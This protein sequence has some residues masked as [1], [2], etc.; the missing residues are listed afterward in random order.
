MG[1]SASVTYNQVRNTVQK[2][3]NTSYFTHIYSADITWT[4]P[5][6]F[7]LATDVDY[8]FNTGLASGFNQNFAI[9][10][11]SIA[12]EVFKTKRGEIRA[13]VF[14]LLNQNT[15]VYRTVNDNYVQDVQNLTLKRYFLLTFSYK[16]NRMGGRS[17]PPMIQRATRGMRIN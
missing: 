12:K 14:D 8:T 13:S 6:N 10:N 5:K 16:I 15:S 17:L 7:I 2:A 9:W 1:V 4:L 11:A 3:S